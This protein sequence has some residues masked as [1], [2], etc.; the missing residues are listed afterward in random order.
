MLTWL[1][2]GLKKQGLF[3]IVAGGCSIAGVLPMIFK[4]EEHETIWALTFT[5]FFIAFCV[6]LNYCFYS[7]QILKDEVNRCSKA[8][9]ELEKSLLKDRR[10]SRKGKKS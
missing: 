4:F 5:G 8:K 3:G 6:L 1:K 9:S 2:E 10:S 7:Q